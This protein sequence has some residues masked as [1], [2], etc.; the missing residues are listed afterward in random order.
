MPSP[1]RVPSLR[2]RL[3]NDAPIAASGRYVL[4]W[5][6]AARRTRRNFALER[7]VEHAR[8]L[9][10]P[11]VVLDALRAGHERANDRLHA[12]AIDGMADVAER[13]AEAGAFPY[14]YVEP[15]PGAG[16][17]LLEALARH[18]CLVVT[19]EFPTYFLPRMVAA[20]ARRLAVRLEVVDAAGLLPMRAAPRAFP[21]ARSFRSFLQQELP[22]H[23]GDAPLDDPL[24]GLPLAP[25][26]L[27]EADVLARFPPMPLA[28]LRDPGA[29]VRALPIDH[30]VGVVAT[31]GG[32]R[33]GERA[34]D[35]F[36]RE[37][38]ARYVDDRNHPDEDATS[39]LSPYLHF[40]HVGA[41]DVFARLVTH[42][43]W[44]PLS[45]G[46]VAAGAREGFWGMSA[47]AE[48]F[49]EQLVTWRE[50]GFNHAAHAGDDQRYESLPAWARATLEKHR[51]DRR[52]VVYDRAR[53]EAAAT[54]DAVWNAAQT[55]LARTGRMHNYLRMLWGKKILEWSPSPEEALATMIDLNDRLALDGR[56]PNS[57]SGILWCLGRYDRAWGPERPIFG[58]VRYMSSDSTVRKLRLRGY[59]ARFAP[60]RG[61]FG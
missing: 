52:P 45:L 59:L 53:L 4:H 38:L 23:L 22:R 47:G 2:V 50:V 58:T 10:K 51:G 37:K 35:V 33:A 49:L 43:G 44:T 39:G 13:L 61:L 41:H 28:A 8:A 12:F 29:I 40:G 19:D 3:A 21:L 25:P 57:Y 1:S 11:L 24:A 48:A 17:G 14:S 26:G 27:V 36:L 46:R 6:I 9:G 55:E 42:E 32:P 34:L 30:R 7:A 60:Q 56:D 5:M 54:G 20:A 16:R 18:A 31:R 15:S